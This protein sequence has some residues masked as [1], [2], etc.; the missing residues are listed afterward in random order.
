MARCPPKIW[1]ELPRHIGHICENKQKKSVLGMLRDAYADIGG[2]KHHR[3]FFARFM[4]PK[5]H[6]GYFA[7]LIKK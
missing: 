5:H 2:P 1:E 4:G 6:R 7:R 3:G